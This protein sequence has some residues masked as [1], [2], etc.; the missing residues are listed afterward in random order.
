[1]SVFT[2]QYYV[3]QVIINARIEE[4]CSNL[5]TSFKRIVFYVNQAYWSSKYYP[6]YAWIIVD[7]FAQSD[8]WN[9]NNVSGRELTNCTQSQ[10]ET[11][12]N[13]SII[14]TPLP[15][16]YN[17]ENSADTKVVCSNCLSTR[18]Q[19][20]CSFI[21]SVLQCWQFFAYAYDAVGSL[22]MALNRTA[23]QTTADDL[24]TCNLTTL[25][26]EISSVQFPGTSV[27]HCI[28]FH[29]PIIHVFQVTHL[30]DPFRVFIRRVWWCSMRMVAVPML[31]SSFYNTD[32][33]K[34]TIIIYSSC[35]VVSPARDACTYLTCFPF[36]V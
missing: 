5:L 4:Y 21:C 18:Y 13:Y 26:N 17:E 1:M 25:M 29:H 22:A 11:V 32:K 7:N 2:A 8:W 19:T 23:C 3:C 30:S 33:A 35:F 12:L 15:A 6:G 24:S 10:F 20:S 27:C 16:D 34:V 36:T 14:V 28:S 31:M 9:V